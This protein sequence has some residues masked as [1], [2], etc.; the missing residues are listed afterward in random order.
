MLAVQEKFINEEECA[1]LEA[2][3]ETKALMFRPAC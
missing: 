3:S 2:N 1:A